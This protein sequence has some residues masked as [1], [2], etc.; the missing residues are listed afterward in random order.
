MKHK[1]VPGPRR[2]ARQPH[3]RNNGRVL[4][5]I[6]VMSVAAGLCIGMFIVTFVEWVMTW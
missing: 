5:F 1:Q 2:H 4:L 3:V 6:V